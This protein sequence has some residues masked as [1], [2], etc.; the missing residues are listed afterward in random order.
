M[1][2]IPY[3]AIQEIADLFAGQLNFI[4][5]DEGITV[6]IYLD[7]DD[8]ERARQKLAAVRAWLGTVPTKQKYPGLDDGE[9]GA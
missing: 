8:A 9:E 3:A 2:D 7:P 6:S 1:T 4:D 5:E